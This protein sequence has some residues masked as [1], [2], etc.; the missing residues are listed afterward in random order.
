MIEETETIENNYTARLQ[1]S[2]ERAL[3]MK[4]A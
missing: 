1:L 4:G 2:A 3:P